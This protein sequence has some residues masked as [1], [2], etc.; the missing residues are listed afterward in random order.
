M[1]NEWRTSRRRRKSCVTVVIFSLLQKNLLVAFIYSV[2]RRSR[3]LQQWHELIQFERNVAFETIVNEKEN[4]NAQALFALQYFFFCKQPIRK[5]Q[6]KSV[7]KHDDDDGGQPHQT[8][9]S[10]MMMSHFFYDFFVL[11]EKNRKRK[12]IN[13][14]SKLNGSLGFFF[15]FAACLNTLQHCIRMFIADEHVFLAKFNEI[16][17]FY[18]QKN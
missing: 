3:C 7:T 14:I 16:S 12:N 11:C 18:C 10:L 13:R 4:Q 17:L 8:F 6:R 15:H 5:R 1:K 9:D 2:M